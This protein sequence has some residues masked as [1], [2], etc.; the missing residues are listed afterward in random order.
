MKF[1]WKMI[2]MVS[3]ILAVTLSIGGSV[4]IW[5]SFQSQIRREI[6]AA[7]DETQLF[8]LLLQSLDPGEDSV[9]PDAV[10]FLKA[11]LR[12]T[13]FLS[14]NRFA[15]T[16][17]SGA[18]ILQTDIMN[19]PIE[20][21]TDMPGIIE[22]HLVES[23]G[24]YVVS[25]TSFPFCGQT[26]QLQRERNVT[27]CFEQAK[28]T[29]RVYEIIMGALLVVS[30]LVTAGFT[31]FLTRPLKRVAGAAVQLTRGHYDQRVTVTSR[32]EVGQVARTFNEMADALESKIKELDDALTRQKEF[33]ASFAHELKTPL[34]SVI[35]YAD[36][37]RSRTLPPEQ[38]LEAA[39]YIVTE[40]RRLEA[41]SFSL[42]DLFALENHAP[43]FSR[44][45]ISQ[46]LEKVRAS[47]SYFLSQAGVGLEAS[48]Q[49]AELSAAPELLHTLLY[50]LIENG[51]KASPQGSVIHLTGRRTEEGYALSVE[52]HGR[53]IPREVLDRITEPFYMVDKSRARAQ[54]G[55]GLG[56]A[57][58]ERI[59][60]IHQADLEFESTQGMGTTVTIVLGGAAQ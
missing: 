12:S 54:G 20:P 7:Q 15:I 57:L 13:D 2:L 33:T 59:A 58:C 27:A 49:E 10:Q 29:L 1:S 26:L 40:G 19:T 37:L 45:S 60:Q 55:A 23:H 38:Q 53:G 34:T 30:T 31:L 47:C 11:K 9:A 36:T 43:N 39:T 25:V 8:S 28:E 46:L 41:M 50:N 32:D 48:V 35:G 24:H 22:S 3:L 14:G 42:L 21:V 16:D 56:L 6:Q 52:D 51:C 17:E 44:V 5:T 18:C 4:I